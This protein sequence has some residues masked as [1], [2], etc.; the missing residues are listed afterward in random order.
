MGG[1]ENRNKENH[2]IHSS[3]PTHNVSSQFTFNS[4]Y[5]LQRSLGS[6]FCDFGGYEIHVPSEILSTWL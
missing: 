3:F 2:C 1:K 4:V 5:V 6:G